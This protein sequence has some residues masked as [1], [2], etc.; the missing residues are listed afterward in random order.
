MSK[1]RAE[2]LPPSAKRT[3]DP[4]AA[5]AALY[6]GEKTDASAIFNTAMAMM[7]V[8]VVYLVFALPFVDILR[9]GPIPGLFLILLPSPL[10][11]IIAFHSLI[12]LTAMRHGGSVRLI[13]NALFEASKLKVKRDMVGSAAGDKIMDITE[14]KLIH[15][16]TT[17]FVYA[18]VGLLVIGFTIYALC[19]AFVVL[20]ANVALTRALV[21]VIAVA[22]IAAYLLVALM[23]ARSWRVGLRMI[24]DERAVSSK[25]MK[26]YRPSTD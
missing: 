18:G 8:A 25:D 11:I 12:T 16:L 10:W 14:A 17:Y 19:C 20:S 15:R 1:S 23:V 22:T 6:Q 4:I 9:R 3:N 21:I 24:K 13:E 2:V 26:Y 7:G 5:L